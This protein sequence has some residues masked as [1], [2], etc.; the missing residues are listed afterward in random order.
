MF[1]PGQAMACAMR[2]LDWPL[3]VVVL[4]GG[5]AFGS[6]FAATID[7]RLPFEG[8]HAAAKR[9]PPYPNTELK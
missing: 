2:R 3:F 1:V 6:L 4:I 9:L 5:I 8:S 7:L